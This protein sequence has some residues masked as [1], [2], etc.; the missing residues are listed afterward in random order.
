MKK[1]ISI[2]LLLFTVFSVSAQISLGTRF[3]DPDGLSYEFQSGRYDSGFFVA[4]PSAEIDN[5]RFYKGDVVIPDS[6]T[7]DDTKYPVYGVGENAFAGCTELTSISLPKNKSI[8]IGTYAFS[9]C[10]GLKTIVVNSVVLD[11]ASD[12]FYGCSGLT[13]INLGSLSMCYLGSYCFENCTNLVSVTLPVNLNL[14]YGRSINPFYYCPSLERINFIN[15]YGNEIENSPNAII[16]DRILI[17]GCKGTVIPDY[18]SEIKTGAFAGSGITSIDIP[19]GVEAIGYG[20][21]DKCKQLVSINIPSSVK[22]LS[23]A[24]SGCDNLSSITVDPDNNVYDSRNNCNAIIE[25]VDIT[26]Y[27]YRLP[28]GQSTRRLLVKDRICVGC[29]NTVIPSSVTSIASGA[30][31][32]CNGLESF[33][34]PENITVVESAAIIYCNDLTS[35]SVAPGHTIY[36]SR[37]NCNA[38]IRSDNDELVV[39]CKNTIIPQGVKTI[40]YGAFSGIS[41]VDAID[42]PEG[43]EG[44][45]AYAFLDCSGLSS[46]TIPEGVSIIG[47]RAFY[48]CSGLQSIFLPSTVRNAGYYMFENCMNLTSLSISDKI[49]CNAPALNHMLSGNDWS[50]CDLYIRQDSL[51]YYSSADYCR[52][53]KVFQKFKSCTVQTSV[54]PVNMDDPRYLGNKTIYDLNG[55]RIMTE[56]PENLNPGIYIIDERKYLKE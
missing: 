17:S 21:F 11:I 32:G 1:I 6:I 22:I 55:R 52:Q 35:I 46:V 53:Y 18:V 38:I 4:E 5:S 3:D 15:E 47:D 50:N 26:D 25:S 16:Q 49:L 20:A 40:G 23:D 27:D 2:S 8:S 44:I 39:A 37:D 43:V 34:L 24:F 45:G 13:D 7:I 54:K 19:Y 31:Y 10:T 28:S 56:S 48:D 9:G 30:F 33:V 12:A 42:I 36:D 51:E 41:E 14:N 29:K